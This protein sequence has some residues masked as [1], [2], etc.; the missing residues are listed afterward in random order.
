M[1]WFYITAL[2]VVAGMV[3]SPML[4]LG[5][6]F[7]E[8][9]PEGVLSW[10]TYGSAIKS[11]DPA[12]CGDVSSASIQSNFYEGLYTY[13]YLKRPVE[14]VPQ[15][16][17]G[18][19]EISEDG[20][21]YTVRLQ[22]GVLYHRNACFGR[23][24]SGSH[25]WSTRPMR[26]EDFVL[27]FKRVADY[28]INT[29]LAWAFLAGRIQ[30]LDD[31]RERTKRYKI[32]DFSRYELPVEGIEA[33]DSLTLRFRLTSPYPQFIYV[34]AIAVYAPIP[35]EVIDYWLTTESDGDGGR[36]AL[37]EHER[38]AEL[39]QPEQVVGTGPYLL[40]EWKRKW[41]INLVRNPEFRQE[42]YPCEGTAA[43][44]ALGLLADCGKR[45]PFVDVL[46]MR[47]TEEDYASWMLFLT[48]QR[49][50]SGIPQETFE[51]VVTP[52]K[53]LAEKWKKQL[54]GLKTY[55]EPAVYWLAFNMEDPILGASRSLRQAICLGFDVESMVEVLYN[56]RGKRAVNTV[57]SSFKGHAEAGPG[58]YYRHD[59]AAAK[60]KLAEAEKELA[61]KGL[62]ENGRIPELKVDVVGD[63]GTAYTSRHADF[64]RQQ[65][66]MLGLR[67]KVVYNDWP[68]L[69][70]KVHN[71]Q[72]QM[73]NMG[74]HADYPDAENFL[75]L[76]YTG[77]ID[78][79]TNNC[80]YSNPE[81]DSLYE[82]VRVMQDS[83]ERTALYA[84]MIR[85]LNEDC[86]V[87]LLTE[88]ERFTLS[89]D[90]M[91]NVKPHPVGYGYTKYHR[92]DTKMRARHGGRS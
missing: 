1:R 42:Y 8:Q 78:K 18:M 21:T 55:S 84:R 11:I 86:P 37:A 22:P 4:L 24:A 41:R 53:A 87:L 68:T 70:R 85:I 59:L 57:P 9:H 20:L 75:Q 2:L 30:G 83:P 26:A 54:V 36:R 7:K 34:L 32:G 91:M 38:S 6:E 45:V 82:T 17:V 69:Q 76:Y 50:A 88:P 74:W 73:Y 31:F 64:L 39:L 3:L 66:A 40:K 13:H 48:K 81:F 61:A 60:A 35:H 51:A 19:P 65:F 23:D 28:H 44:S 89:Y 58:P 10:S 62:L 16:A 90:W 33:V 63:A 52:D 14:V 79:G 67:L 80:N 46:Q 5:D 92:I 27:A 56:G 77:N 12:T 43:D 49:D 29:G 15:L 72:A 71:K 25:T 47:Y